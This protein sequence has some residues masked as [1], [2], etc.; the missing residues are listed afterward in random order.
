MLR[1]FFPLWP[2]SVNHTWR[3]GCG[4]TYLHPKA[5]TFRK[6]IMAEIKR[7]RAAKLLPR[8]GTE[9][10]VRVCLAF[11]PPT[12]QK[13]DLDN[14]LKATLDAFTVADVWADDS[15]VV[16]IGAE[17]CAPVGRENAGFFAEVKEIL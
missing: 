7:A 1:Q 9:K 5:A 11:Y 17:M 8:A 10:P 13:R 4:R 14:L 16:W 2:P 15:Q 12:A 6:N 3:N